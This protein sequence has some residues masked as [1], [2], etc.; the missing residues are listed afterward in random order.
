MVVVVLNLGGK[1]M[2]MEMETLAAPE[3]KLGAASLCTK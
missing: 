2:E 1:G 3:E